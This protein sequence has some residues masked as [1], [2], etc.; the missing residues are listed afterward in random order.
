MSLLYSAASNSSCVFAHKGNVTYFI[1]SNANES[2]IS[3]PLV[4]GLHQGLN[5]EFA[6]TDVTVQSPRVWRWSQQR[7]HFAAPVPLL[8]LSLS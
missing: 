2:S 5:F 3:N 1:R 7:R 8:V 6:E 4:F